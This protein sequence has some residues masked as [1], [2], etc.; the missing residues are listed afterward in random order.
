MD[1]YSAASSATSLAST[2]TSLAS[3]SNPHHQHLQQQSPTDLVTDYSQ[4][5]AASSSSAAA[6][7][8]T[9]S[10]HILPP[11]LQRLP[12]N[13]D[14]HLHSS[15][16]GHHNLLESPEHQQSSVPAAS[17]GASLKRRHHEAT[18]SPSDRRDQES[19]RKVLLK[20]VM[21]RDLM[22]QSAIFITS[23]LQKVP[24]SILIKCHD[25]SCFFVT[26]FI[27]KSGF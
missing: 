7:T 19:P 5:G 1:M 8:E 12:S 20:S 25:K 6:G 11:S 27:L 3:T 15:G 9:G 16:R 2:A 24:G 14:H 21:M 23:N 10:T 17:S 13:V 22:W 26:A 18:T 4:Q